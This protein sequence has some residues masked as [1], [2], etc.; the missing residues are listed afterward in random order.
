MLDCSM[1]R[2]DLTAPTLTI[3]A[4]SVEFNFASSNMSV[5]VSSNEEG[6]FT[7][8]ALNP[9]TFA[10]LNSTDFP[11]DLGNMDEYTR[12]DVNNEDRGWLLCGV[13]CDA[14]CSNVAASLTFASRA[15]CACVCICWCTGTTLTVSVDLDTS[16]FTVV[17][18]A[19]FSTFTL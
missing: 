16:A 4:G 5:E 19:S 10:E 17:D 8:Y 2:Y 7:I 12:V 1:R 6:N 14:M 9:D 18:D 11:Q 15:R 3:D 13:R